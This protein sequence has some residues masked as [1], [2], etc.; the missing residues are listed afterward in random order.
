[1]MHLLRLAWSH[2]IGVVR[3][4]FGRRL[5]KIFVISG[6]LVIL[7]GLV[8][9]FGAPF[10]LRDLVA[11]K[12]SAAIGRPIEVQ[13]I[14]FN[15]YTLHL[16]C[17]WLTIAEPDKGPRK[18]IAIY[19][20]SVRISW[21]TLFRLKPI[22][23][24]ITIDRPV[25]SI[26]RK[27]DRTFNFSDLLAK[28]SSSTASAAP[29]SPM[30]YAVSNIRINAGQM[31]FTDELL[32]TH[33]VI[34]KI[35][36]GVPFIANL[37][38]DADVYVHPMVSMIIDGSP[39]A[40]TGKMQPFSPTRQSTLALRLHRLNLGRYLQYLPNQPPVTLPQAALSALLEI[41]FSMPDSGPA[42]RLNGAVSLDNVDLRDR[43]NA[44]VLALKHSEITLVNVEPLSGNVHLG[45]FFVDGLSPSVKIG[46]D[47]KLNYA[48]LLATTTAVPRK[49]PTPGS[50][51]SIPPRATAG[52]IAPGKIQSTPVKPTAATPGAIEPS[53]MSAAPAVAPSLVAPRPPP[54]SPARGAFNL[55][56]DSALLINSS[57]TLSDLGAT[58]AA[59]ASISG[60]TFHLKSLST[61]PGGSAPFD[62]TAKLGGGGSIGLNGTIDLAASSAKTTIKL[63]R[64]ALAPYS[65]FIA[66]SLPGGVSSGFLGVEANVEAHLTKNA[67]N[68][69]VAPA[70]IE[71]NDLV[72]GALSSE[73]H[74]ISLKTLKILI[75]QVDL[76]SHSASLKE[77][78]FD[79]LDAFVKREKN[80]AINLESLGISPGARLQSAQ[81]ARGAISN[82]PEVAQGPKAAPIGKTLHGAPHP[83][84]STA[85]ASA[86]RWAVTEVAVRQAAVDFD[87]ET[88]QPPLKLSV[89]AVNFSA[90]NL[91]NEMSRAVNFDLNLG[92][93]RHGMVRLDGRVRPEPFSTKMKVTV[94]R[95]DVATFNP[96]IGDRLNAVIASASF[97]SVGELML[98][99]QHKAT[100]IGYSGDAGLYDVRLLDKVNRRLFARWRKLSLGGIDVHV[101]QSPT[102]ARVG[103][104]ALD[105][106][107]ARV[108]LN[109]DGRLN[110]RDLV[111]SPTSRPKSL[112]VPDTQAAVEN[113][114]PRAASGEP[115][116]NIISIG[117]IALRGGKVDYSDYFIKPNYHADLSDMAGNVGAFGSSTT[118]P[119]PVQLSGKINGSAPVDIHGLVNPLV[120]M[121]YLDLIATADG[122]ELTGLSAYSTKY[123]GYPIESGTLSLN[124]HYLLD[125]R[126]LT[127]EN[128]ILLNQLTFGDH[129]DTPGALNLPIRLA[130]ALLKDP[131]GRINLNV[132][133]SGSLS[134]PKFSI[135]AVM[136]SAVSNLIVKAAAAPFNLLASLVG[137][138]AKIGGNGAALSEIE[139]EPGRSNLSS[140]DK[141]KLA[142]LAKAL[143]ERPALQLE[144][145]GKVYPALDREGLRQALV[146]REVALQKLKELR[147]SGQAADL[148]NLKLSSGEYDEYLKK[149]YQEAKFE[150][151]TNFLGFD[152][153]LP[154][155]EMNKLLLQHT[156]V[157]DTDLRRLANDRANRV[158][159][160]LSER[161]SP[162]RL[163]VAHPNLDATLSGA[164]SSTVAGVK[165]ALQ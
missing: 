74:P 95:L 128:K 73:P 15:P 125:Q 111:A 151:P 116:N 26:V 137:S 123:T 162:R 90:H 161:V 122:I 66:R 96:Y 97:D 39:F 67:P 30:L 78:S 102:V 124:V 31:R 80:G 51:L 112:T 87:D 62:F 83:S 155:A 164:K 10:L 21:Q 70:R 154:P 28:F 36:I 132:P 142:T 110:V 38:A 150:K 149:V 46:P 81:H 6:L 18:F 27:R 165:L 25:I 114:T 40:L 7:F 158:R 157:T 120:P 63:D 134:D 58:P 98:A 135:G 44:Q 8:G 9:H 160:W 163:L 34:S 118:I 156:K 109:A 101:G 129:V 17:G 84:P 136:W 23:Q 13:A 91:S 35:D 11:P 138:I 100:Q 113:P 145:K 56:L 75:D 45:R 103:S 159:A 24:E 20:M 82:T 131:Q 88:T 152:K 47:G 59:T 53:I 68:V 52:F 143:Q 72:L 105:N 93:P 77:I 119:A 16:G 49:S 85:A 61:T 33:H 29:K 12:I 57:A 64:V 14:D 140:A 144:I 94:R 126:K 1:M 106:F 2:W 89:T 139:F 86:W 148:E 50:K 76:A 133:I 117:Q 107:Y 99:R 43:A 127:A 146:D 41:N 3:G 60:I 121:A 42:V 69:H 55:T 153:S 65:P 130:V 5:V 141:D 147:A 19:R 108:I 79:K 71:V 92:L 37:K 4:R 115:S 32:A 22:V 54:S 48:A 104:V